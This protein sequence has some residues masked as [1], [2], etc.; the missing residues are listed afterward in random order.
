[1]I[2]CECTIPGDPVPKA[3]PRQGKGGHTY[4]PQRTIDA[5]DAIAWALRAA[6]KGRPT[7][8]LVTISLA[9]RCATRRRAD[10]D[11]LAK[12]VLDAGNGIVYLDDQQ[13]GRLV[14]DVARGV[15]KANAST[16]VVIESLRR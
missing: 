12:L 3:R 7:S 10:V 5:E 8:Q 4:T 16:T 15:G 11:N 6:Y 9:F 13:V 14:V 1:M 2:L